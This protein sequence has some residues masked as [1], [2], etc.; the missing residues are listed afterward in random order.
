[1]NFYDFSDWLGSVFEK[2]ALPFVVAVVVILGIFFILYFVSRKMK[3]TAMNQAYAL[4]TELACHVLGERFRE[5]LSYSPLA[6]EISEKM[7]GSRHT[8]FLA[9]ANISQGFDDRFKEYA[10]ESLLFS[11]IKLESLGEDIKKTIL[12]WNKEDRN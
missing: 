5:G 2:I 8:K 9:R 7:Q 1:M 11:F 3:L 12:Q 6:Q 10:H 4:L